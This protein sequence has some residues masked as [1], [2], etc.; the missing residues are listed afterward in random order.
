MAI[1]IL[2]VVGLCLG[3]FVNALV[4]RLH[5]QELENSK[6]KISSK[7][8]AELSIV[9]GHSMCPHCK[10]KL[11][12]IDLIPLFSWLSVK[13]KCRYCGEPI[14]SQYPLV[15][16]ITAL[17]FIASY[18]WW[19]FHIYGSQLVLFIFWLLLLVGLLALILYDLRWFL[20]PN[21][22]IYPL[23]CLALIYAIT[24]VI[25]AN[26]PLAALLNTVI[27]VAIGGGIFYALFQLSNGRWIGGGDVRLGWLLGLIAGTPGRSILFIF[28]ASIL[29]TIVSLP[30]LSAHRLKR[31]SV[32]PFGPFLIA[33][34][35][36]TQLFGTNIIHWYTTAF[37]NIH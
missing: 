13:G 24:N 15:E 12:A 10:H 27:A 20:L 30:L 26:R 36:I 16:L 31:S 32:I 7:R 28:L 25:S 33:G 2:A 4:W 8:L 35:I 14:S 5:E 6:K 23:G 3:S 34:A 18:I 22:I 9:K 37:L 19:P 1:V 21:R 17:L 11:A 29:G